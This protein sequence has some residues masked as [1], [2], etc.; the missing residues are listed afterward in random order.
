[1][2]RDGVARSGW[3]ESG[4]RVTYV[5]MGAGA[6]CVLALAFGLLGPVADEA[7]LILGAGAVAAT[8]VGLRRNR[9]AVRW[10]WV[11][12]AAALIV[13]LVGGGVR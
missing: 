4:A 10:P 11:T 9:P 1:M 7:F 8:L 5:V 3:V 6:I 12:I 13:F 2:G